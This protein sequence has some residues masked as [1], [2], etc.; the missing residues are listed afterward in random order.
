MWGTSQEVEN[1]RERKVEGLGEG[2][3]DISCVLIV[4]Q[5]ERVF[6]YG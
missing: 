1:Q 4:S 5:K 2:E 3:K 6:F